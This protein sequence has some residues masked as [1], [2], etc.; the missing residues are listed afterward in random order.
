MRQAR[1]FAGTEEERKRKREGEE[2][3]LGIYNW[4][5][6]STPQSIAYSRW[7]PLV[8]NNRKIDNNKRLPSPRTSKKKI[9]ENIVVCRSCVGESA[10][11]IRVT[12]DRFLLYIF[13][14]REYSFPNNSTGNH[15]SLFKHDVPP[16]RYIRMRWSSQYTLGI[17]APTK[18]NIRP[19]P[20][21]LTYRTTA[22]LIIYVHDGRWWISWWTCAN[23]MLEHRPMNAKQRCDNVGSSVHWMV[24]YDILV[25]IFA[26]HTYTAQSSNSCQTKRRHES[27]EVTE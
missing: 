1:L 12:H 9:E 24:S 17:S 15:S 23:R 5:L 26:A 16:D 4:L 6:T 8:N 14:G 13:P 21:C 11:W 2:R 3:Q 7:F 25:H 10:F 27:Y 18:R 22:S 20:K 19:F